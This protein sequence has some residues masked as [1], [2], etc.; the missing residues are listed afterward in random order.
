[1]K[2]RGS[3]KR[4]PLLVNAIMII[5]KSQI[6]N[7][8]QSSN[9]K[10]LNY[11]PFR[12][13]FVIWILSFVILSISGCAP[14]SV[15]DEQK[16]QIVAA[17][18]AFE[19]VLKAKSVYDAQTADLRQKFLSDKNMFEAKI[20]ALRSEFEAKKAQ[21]YKEQRQIKAQLDPEREKIRIDVDILSEDYRNKLKSQKAIMGMLSEAKSITEGKFGSNLSSKEKAEWAKRFESLNEEY[22]RITQEVDSAKEKLNILKLKQRSLIQ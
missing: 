17:D 6:Q 20:A 11:L 3:P 18:P 1:M 19:K 4:E 16:K 7:P 5:S 8:N 2:T 13:S 15:S 21:F 14:I 10:Y 9:F 22:S 12:Y